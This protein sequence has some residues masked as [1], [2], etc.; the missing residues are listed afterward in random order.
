MFKEIREEMNLSRQD[1]AVKLGITKSALWKIENGVSIPK[2]T[3][4]AAL[5]L[6]SRVPVARIQI[7]ALQPEDYK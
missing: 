4:I 7:G 3:T 1:L 2:P 5:A 6:V